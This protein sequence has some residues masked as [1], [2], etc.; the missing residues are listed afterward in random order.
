MIHPNPSPYV[1]VPALR[2]RETAAQRAARVAE[3]QI[4]RVA[5]ELD[6][7]AEADAQVSGTATVRG[8]YRVSG[9]VP[10]HLLGTRRG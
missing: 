10:A 4:A 1:T 6:R 2:R 3:D 7:K 8:E 9:P 5:R